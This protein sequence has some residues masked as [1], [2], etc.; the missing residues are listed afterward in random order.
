MDTNSK[1]CV[2]YFVGDT[3]EGKDGIMSRFE[4]ELEC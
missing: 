4:L 1:N 2:T 3:I